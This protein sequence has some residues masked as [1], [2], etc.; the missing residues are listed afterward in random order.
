ME[1]NKCNVET[2]KTLLNSADEEDIKKGLGLVCEALDPFYP[3]NPELELDT[4]TD[5][6]I[7]EILTLVSFKLDHISIEIRA[8]AAS[9]LGTFAR[10]RAF[11]RTSKYLGYAL[12][13]LLE[14]ME[15]LP[16]DISATQYLW[17]LEYLHNWNIPLLI[18]DFCVKLAQ[19]DD[20]R[21]KGWGV[22]YLGIYGYSDDVELLV[23]C[24]EHPDELVRIEALDSLEKL[25]EKGYGDDRF[26]AYKI[27][28]KIYIRRLLRRLR[29][30]LKPNK[31]SS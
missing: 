14:R 21:V 7:K 23:S 29:L 26:P 3:D 6:D 4:F 17:S 16:A 10:P 12:A 18:R 28:T 13:P 31:P 30:L 11:P 9:C 1:E 15:T 19:S 24:L 25:W 5:E 20:L 2:V 8:G 27:R 22:Q